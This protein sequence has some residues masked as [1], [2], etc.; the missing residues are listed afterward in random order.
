MNPIGCLAP[1][2]VKKLTKPS[3]MLIGKVS[4]NGNL[5][6]GKFGQHLASRFQQMMDTFFRTISASSRSETDR[7]R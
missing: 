5:G 2:V 6:V 4:G 7:S 1:C 3:L